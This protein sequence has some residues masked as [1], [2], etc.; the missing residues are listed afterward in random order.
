M[1]RTLT[2]HISLPYSDRE[3]IVEL[4]KTFVGDEVLTYIRDVLKEK[5]PENPII[6][7]VGKDTRNHILIDNIKLEENT[8]SSSIKL[9]IIPEMMNLSIITPDHRKITVKVPAVHTVGD[10]VKILCEKLNL[11]SVFDYGLYF[12]ENDSLLSSLKVNLPLCENRAVITELYM[13]RRWWRQDCYKNISADELNFIYNQ[14]HKEFVDMPKDPSFWDCIELAGIYSVVKFNKDTTRFK[15]VLKSGKT[16]KYY[17]KCVEGF[18]NSIKI[19][20]SFENHLKQDITTLKQEFVKK[21]LSYEFA[22]CE[23]FPIYKDKKLRYLTAQGEY[24]LIIKKDKK[25]VVDRYYQLKVIRWQPIGQKELH[26]IYSGTKVEDIIFTTKGNIDIIRFLSDY[27]DFI[28]PILQDTHRKSSREK[29]QKKIEL[30]I[31]PR[32]TIVKTEI[33]MPSITK[34]DS[35]VY[36]KPIP[37]KIIYPCIPTLPKSD[38]KISKSDNKIP[39]SDNKISKSGTQ[40]TKPELKEINIDSKPNGFAKQCINLIHQIA[41]NQI[42][43]PIQKMIDFITSISP[44]SVKEIKFLADTDTT[45][46]VI[47][48]NLAARAAASIIINE[49]HESSLFVS[50]TKLGEIVMLYALDKSWSFDYSVKPNIKNPTLSECF[51]NLSTEELKVEESQ[52][53]VS[54]IFCSL[55]IFF[56]ATLFLLESE[57][58]RSELLSPQKNSYCMPCFDLISLVHLL[59]IVGDKNT[60]KTVSI[61]QSFVKTIRDPSTVFKLLSSY[62]SNLFEEEPQSINEYIYIFEMGRVI[63]YCLYQVRGGFSVSHLYGVS[64]CTLLCSNSSDTK[65]KKL[66]YEYFK[67]S[68]NKVNYF[69]MNN[70]SFTSCVDCNES[71][72]HSFVY[73]LSHY[74]QSVSDIE[75]LMKVTNSISESDRYKIFSDLVDVI[76]ESMKHNERDKAVETAKRLAFLSMSFNLLSLKNYSIKMLDAV[77]KWSHEEI[78]VEEA[79]KLVDY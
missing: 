17:P 46:P 52:P 28:T 7:V 38:N 71:M 44:Q 56:H 31:S 32:M 20:K 19:Q 65:T 30:Q 6:L 22:F 10:F 76:H 72:F 66:C 58:V 12:Q 13:K 25:T 39:K 9:T 57:R 77:H 4:T 70:I 49:C 43:L 11:S 41:K 48:V 27:F 53:L 36:T 14:I 45:S 34:S 16:Q 67:N 64:V 3:L 8:N 69:C 42:V 23:L 61:L 35:V 55:N 73:E 37:S 79:I 74:H 5:I 21:F 51:V 78:S 60:T 63:S 26:L 24:V 15:E 62:N 68:V 50:L 40:N 1:K 59:D 54:L 29:R 75:K 18:F 33:S 47:A 2:T